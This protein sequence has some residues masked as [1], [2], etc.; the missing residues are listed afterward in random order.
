MLK[1]DRLKIITDI[2]NFSELNESLFTTNI[3]QNEILSLKYQQQKPFYLS[4][5]VNNQMNQLELEFTGKILLDDYKELINKNSIR[6]CLQ[7]INEMGLCKLNV[8]QILMDAIVTKCDITQDVCYEDIN[9]VI[10][11]IRQN[12]LNYKKWIVKEYKDGLIIENVVKTLRYKKRLTIY[13]K[14]KEL[15]NVDNNFFLEILNNKEAL[16]AYFNNKIRF[17]LNLKTRK[18]IREM[19][20]ISDNSISSVLNSKSNPILIVLNEFL[21]KNVTEVYKST[22]LKEYL[23]TL[24]LKECNYDLNMVEVIVRSLSSKNRSIQRAM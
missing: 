4:I 19:L 17:E 6:K 7:M 3:K 15:S 23:Y 2:S 14:R 16:L 1:L 20:Q 12:L 8:E 5:V 10:T 13:N 21:N 9:T 18:Q 11:Y 22:N 24:L